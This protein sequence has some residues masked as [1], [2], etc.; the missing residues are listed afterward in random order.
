MRDTDTKMKVII[1]HIICLL[2]LSAC[3]V[4]GQVLHEL[5]ETPFNDKVNDDGSA[6][7]YFIRTSEDRVLKVLNIKTKASAT[8]SNI[9]SETVLTNELL[10]AF[11]YKHK[12]LFRVGLNEMRIDTLKQVTDYYWLNNHNVLV[13]KEDDENLKMWDA[14]NNKTRALGQAKYLELSADKDKM[15]WGTEELL[16]LYDFATHKAKTWNRKECGITDPVKKIIWNSKGSTAYVCTSNASEYKIFKLDNRSCAAVFSGKIKPD[17]SQT[18]ID[19]LFGSVRVLS[20]RYIALPVKITLPDAAA[21]QPEIWLGKTTGTTPAVKKDMETRTQLG[22]ADLKNGTFLNLATAKQNVRFAVSH[23]GKK[24]FSYELGDDS[25]QLIP[26]IDVYMYTDDFKDKQK[27]DTFTGYRE[28]MYNTEAFP[29]ILYLK[30]KDWILYDYKTHKRKAFTKDSGGIF[31]REND[32]YHLK[33][34]DVVLQRMATLRNRWLFFYDLNDIWVY[35]VPHNNYKKVTQ[36]SDQSRIYRFYTHHFEMK[37]RPFAFDYDRRLKDEKYHIVHWSKEDY[38]EE[39]LSLLNDAFE[40]KELV[41]DKAHYNQMYL[42]KTVIS[43]IKEKASTPPALYVYDIATGKET[44][45]YQS[46][47]ADEQAKN[48]QT[49][50]VQ[51]I[52]ED[53]NRQGVIVRYP[54]NYD[55]KQLY[56]AVVYIYEDK[57]KEQNHYQSPFKPSEIGFNHRTY[58]DNGYFVLEPDIYYEYGAPGKSAARCVLKALDKALEKCSIDPDKVGLTGHSFGGYETNYIIT[59]T[60]RFKAAVSGAGVADM[61]TCYFSVNNRNLRS[62]SWRFPEQ[63]FRMKKGFFDLT[64]QYME[65]S[66]VFQS[67]QISTP[68]LL[69]S[70]KKDSSVEPRQSVAMFL[71]LKNQRKEVNMLLYE[72]EDHVLNSMEN[73]IDLQQKMFSW[74]NYYL[75]GA[76]QPEWIKEGLP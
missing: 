58:T 41:K 36:G 45:V 2:V 53:G 14:A 60:N 51:W 64:H 71:A 52:N 24:V 49:E 1:F 67:S 10:L 26:D 35:D 4:T 63:C 50:Y 59:Q 29:F 18:V 65:N 27:L 38:T 15:V 40:L 57:A 42:S 61:T 7:T 32:L 37:T 48:L 8:F 74:F 11:D 76:P 25:N 39:G 43:Y 46:G 72:K 34:Y 66:P 13:Y 70:G 21:S 73:K 47:M 5:E 62:E 56:P 44:L 30:D 16:K 55:P 69:W 20:D 28:M 17:H 6:V 9:V 33:Q 22:I 31:Y 68:L 12:Q 3:P 19:T 54:L 75:K 23:D